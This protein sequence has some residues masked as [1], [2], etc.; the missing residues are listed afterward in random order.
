[1]SIETLSLFGGL[2]VLAALVILG[3]VALFVDDEPPLF[4]YLV[5][6]ILVVATMVLFAK[7]GL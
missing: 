1:M 6:V 3:V 5:G 7:A 2:G 4:T